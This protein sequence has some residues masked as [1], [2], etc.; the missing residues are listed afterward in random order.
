MQAE[1]LD[2]IKEELSNFYLDI[3]T[4]SII[5]ELQKNSTINE[6]FLVE[7]K[8]SFTR[9][10]RR[11]LLKSK[12]HNDSQLLLELSRNGVYDLL[13]EGFFHSTKNE[14]G[15][16]SFNAKRKKKKKEE[17]DSRL[18]FS[19]IE[20]ELFRQSVDILKKEKEL[21]DNFYSLNND[22]LFSFWTLKKYAT[23]KYVSKLVELLPYCYKIAGD[24]E[25]TKY[26]LEKII[27]Q[28]VEFVKKFKK[29]ETIQKDN[30]DILGMS[31]V[32]QTKK[33][34]I[35]V[36]LIEIKIG[37]ISQLELREFCNDKDVQDFLSL[38]YK[39]FLPLEFEITTTFLNNREQKFILD[40]TN[41]PI[42][43]VSTNI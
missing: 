42:I 5:L 27:E 17:K 16:T 35:A 22:F 39:Y 40:D 23:N 25:L 4:E 33:T 20:N 37:P 11:D 31:L 14:K 29:I 36:P 12:I 1:K 38:F 6:D 8:S 41:N 21:L 9:P 3:K 18:L 13:P 30:N 34:R 26:Y 15:I 19:P 7:N 43:G 28:K 10:H 32:T 2:K 24:L